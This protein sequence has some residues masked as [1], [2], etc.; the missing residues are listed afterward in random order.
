MQLALIKQTASVSHLQL[1]SVSAF[2]LRNQARDLF[3]GNLLLSS[4]STYEQNCPSFK[5]HTGLGILYI[6]DRFH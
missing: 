4:I 1:T 5:S 6:N 2:Y 3:S